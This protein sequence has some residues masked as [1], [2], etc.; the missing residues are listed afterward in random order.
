[1]HH[2]PRDDVAF[3]CRPERREVATK[4]LGARL[5]RGEGLR[6]VERDESSLGAAVPESGLV[7]MEEMCAL[8]RSTPCPPRVEAG[9]SMLT[10]EKFEGIG[11]RHVAL[12]RERP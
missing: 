7:M 1:M 4:H 10:L 5:E 3:R 12:G 6:L 9:E 11:R 2:A 8:A